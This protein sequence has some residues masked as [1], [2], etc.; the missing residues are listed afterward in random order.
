[1]LVALSLAGC[2]RRATTTSVPTPTAT[3]T[4]AARTDLVLTAPSTEDG[5]DLDLHLHWRAARVRQVLPAA[6]ERWRFGQYSDLVVRDGEAHRALLLLPS[7]DG[8]ASRASFKV[9]VP[10]ESACE[11]VTW[12]ALES[13]VAAKSDGVDVGVALTDGGS[14]PDAAPIS[15]TRLPGG[16]PRAAWREVRM[17]LTDR[18]G[19]TLWVILAARERENRSGDWLLFGDPRL[20]AKNLRH[21]LI[22]DVAR[23]DAGERRPRR[24]PWSETN[25]FKPY[26]LF[27]EGHVSSVP[28]Q[29][30]ARAFPWL[31]SVR[32]FSAL[33]ANWGPTLARD[34][35]AQI[36]KNPTMDNRWETD[37]AREYEFF[38]D[39]GEGSA[40][41]GAGAG[42]FEWTSFDHLLDALADSSLALHLNLAGAP[43]AF[44]GRHGHYD[45]Y[46]FNEL[47]VADEAAW[48][49]YV[50]TLFA[51]LAS[52]PWFA[53]A[54]LS[55]FNEPN[56]RW[57]ETDGTVRK[58][59]YQGDAESYARQY[60]ATW[61]A[62]KPYLRPGQVHL[63]PFVAEP[64]RDNA[65]TNN[66]G[67]F[68]HALHRAFDDGGE[69]LPPWSA[70]AF[71]VYDTPQLTLDGLA[72]TK[73][74]YVRELLDA[75]F[76]GLHLP[77][78]FDE[79]GLHPVI[80]AAFAAA[81]AGNLDATRWASAW[82][83]EMLALLVDQEI[84]R[85]SPWS[86]VFSRHSFAPYFFASVVAGTIDYRVAPAGEITLRR[87]DDADATASL[88]V[89][90]ASRHGDRVGALWSV[91]PEGR[92][93]RIALW[94]Y[95]RFAMSDVRLAADTDARRVVVRLP[96]PPSGG[97]RV[98][99]TTEAGA[100][101]PVEDCGVGEAGRGP[102]MRVPEVAE[103]PPFRACERT[104][105][106][107][108]Q[109]DLF[110]GDV[111]LV[112]ISGGAASA[113]GASP[114]TS[115]AQLEAQRA[116]DQDQ[117]HQ[118]YE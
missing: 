63:G 30:M 7:S 106:D 50:D 20:R 46:H 67:E 25:V 21:E 60:L 91:S 14:D 112:E 102:T 80:T 44:T 62:M 15:F 93:W 22:L 84:Q 66:L 9:T 96:P 42:R 1:M 71:N 55:F 49:A 90:L 97:W 61:R 85:A 5:G 69:P 43:E 64:D 59:G 35:G 48:R 73:I 23:P 31:E 11:L 2:D 111:L 68:L 110:A 19:Q 53:R 81:G 94:H 17:D 45:T 77:L 13:N 87:R 10:A 36:G 83:A 114:E 109:L 113:S 37:L 79:V 54:Q 117:R 72:A 118:R 38:R 76:P 16:D 33:G 57:T 6:D 101:V 88:F 12:V 99:V 103:A 4:I 116:R 108:V 65:I 52:R 98:R 47:P 86:S 70:F 95:P 105:D 56:C 41:A 82:H 89:R 3:T 29:W 24:A 34:E 27:R 26:A 39:D 115:G 28:V 58:F 32:L 92:T 100:R 74:A 40:G 8:A 75:E 18:R 107:R 104:V 78:R 51:H